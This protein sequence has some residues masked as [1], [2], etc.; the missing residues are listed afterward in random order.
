MMPTRQWR[1]N[2]SHPPTRLRN[3]C[4]PTSNL[5]ALRS[6]Y[7]D[8]LTLESVS[9]PGCPRVNDG[10]FVCVRREGPICIIGCLQAFDFRALPLD[11]IKNGEDELLSLELRQ[12]TPNRRYIAA[13]VDV[14]STQKNRARASIHGHAH[15][16]LGG[17]ILVRCHRHCVQQSVTG[18]AEYGP[19]VTLPTRK[20]NFRGLLVNSLLENRTPTTSDGMKEDGFAVS[21]PIVWPAVPLVQRQASWIKCSGS[22]F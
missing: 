14:F 22:E 7:C 19:F 17:V 1:I 6:R 11:R 8:R 21:G 10:D 13:M 5:A 12:N 15:E 3:A 2:G 9:R 18:R 4:F 20:Q 16:P